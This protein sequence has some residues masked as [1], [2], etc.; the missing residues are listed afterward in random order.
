ML[1]FVVAQI[2]NGG[3]SASD[4]HLDSTRDEVPLA[5]QRLRA[6]SYPS[7]NSP[8][9]N[10]QQST[11]KRLTGVLGTQTDFF[12]GVIS[13]I[14]PGS[15]LNRFGIRPGDRVVGFN[16]HP[17]TNGQDMAKRSERRTGNGISNA[18]PAS[19]CGTQYKCSKEGCTHFR[20]PCGFNVRI[21]ANHESQ[22]L[23]RLRLAESP[24]V[25]VM[26]MA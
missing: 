9:S 17:Y 8:V 26:T 2:L 13:I 19:R 21:R 6:A 10:V 5:P 25:N 15:D 4:V 14:L 24:V 7:D 1:E 3:I 11:G 16:N 18:S 22:S 12:T 20:T 23:S